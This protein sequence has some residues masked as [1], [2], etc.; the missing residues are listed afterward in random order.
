MSDQNVLVVGGGIGGVCAALCFARR[1]FDVHVFEQA[2]DFGA[3]G[4]GIQLTPNA[5]RVLHDLGLEDALREVAVLPEAV[6]MR[7]WNSG[8]T[9]TSNPL[10]TQLVAD[11]GFPYYHVH[12]TDLMQVLVNAART[13]SGIRLHSSA[14]VRSIDRSDFGVSLDAAGK[15]YQGALLIGADGI[16][17]MVRTDLFGPEAPRFTGN[18]AWRCL[19]QADQL[20]QGLVHRVASVWW[21]PHKHFV[22]YYVRGGALVNCVCVVEKDGWEVES[23]NERGDH[24]ELK[25]DFAGWHETVGALIDNM[26]PEECF[27]WALFDRAPMPR[28][29]QGRVTLL[30]DACHPTLPF[31]A[32]GAAMAIEDGAVLCRCVFEGDDIARS[33]QRYESLRRQRTARIQRGSRRNA[34]VFH[35]SGISARVRNRVV[36]RARGQIMDW[37]YRYDALDESR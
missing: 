11:Y 1:G 33:L 21:G 10:G 14:A 27:K 15:H 23:W 2:T 37:L 29:S 13:Q 20:P 31:M 4:A 19:V 9:L 5:T 25:A 7:E 30:G 17:S 12:R 28:W 34:K 18:V 8:R 16:H 36:G 6:E 22:H 3:T 32:Q 24:A 35:L 26:D